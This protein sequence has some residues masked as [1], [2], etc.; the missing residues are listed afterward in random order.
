MLSP[1]FKQLQQIK[2]YY[3]FPTTLDVDRYTVNGKAARRRRSACASS[4]S[5]GLP[6][7]QRNWIN[8][9]TV[10]THGYGFVAALRQRRPT[11]GRP[12]FVSSRHPADGQLDVT[13]PR[14]YFGEESPTYSIVGAP[15]GRDA[16]RARLPGRHGEPGQQN[17][18]YDGQAAA[19]P[20]GSLWHRLL[21][22]MKYQEPNILLSGPGQRRLAGSSTSATPKERVEKVAPWLTLD[23][24]P[25]P[26]VVDGT[27]RSGSSTATR[28]PTATRTRT[29]THA[30]A[31]RRPTRAR[32]RNQQ[33]VTP[34]QTQVNYIRNSVK[35]TV[36]AYDGT[37]TLYAVGRPGPGAEDLDEGLPRHGPAAGRDI[38]DDL[39]AHLRYPE[40]LFK[41]QRE[42]LAS[43]HVTDPQTFY[44]GRTS[45]RSRTTRRQG[46]AGARSRRTT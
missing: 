29:R 12:S 22:A 25:Y 14:I 6:A 1:T 31:T 30:R 11:G 8:D 32:P 24:D 21:Y 23:G 36:D 40:D 16:A 3:D 43:Y 15:A 27:D 33:L 5:T 10:Y 34:G 13:Q 18:T 37:V 35:A 46:A 17:N 39:M 2:A 4:T 38:R 9:H 44:S 19:S 42:L 26:A 41:V 28:R 7:A 45:G 20:I